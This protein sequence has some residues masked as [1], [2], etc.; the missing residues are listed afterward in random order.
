MTHPLATLLAA[1]PLL[2]AAPAPGVDAMRHHRRVVIASAPRADD[3]H[4]LDQRRALEGWRAGAADR[5]VSLIEIAGDH[6]IGAS[7]RADVLRRRFDLPADRFA[8]VLIG[9]DGHVA[10]RAAAPFPAAALQ[11]TI[12]AMPMRRAGRR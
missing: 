6:V 2:A 1:L 7:D 3:P 8:A 9:K 4:L 10:D 12:D 11:A 5:D